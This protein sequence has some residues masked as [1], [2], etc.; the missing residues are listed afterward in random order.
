MEICVIGTGYVGLV[1]G[2]CFAETGND[3]ICVDVDQKKID[4]LHKGIIRFSSRSLKN[5]SSGTLRTGG[6][7]F[8]PISRLP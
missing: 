8:R 6:F 1:A 2:T 5:S 3:V 7:S 4:L